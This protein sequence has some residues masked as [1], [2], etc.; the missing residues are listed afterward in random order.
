MNFTLFWFQK[1]PKNNKEGKKTKESSSVSAEL[2][3]IAFLCTKLS[4]VHLI[5]G[6]P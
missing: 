2:Q 1:E 5:Q 6:C 4:K 3:G